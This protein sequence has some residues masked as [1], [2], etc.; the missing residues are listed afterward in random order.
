MRATDIVAPLHKVPDEYA[1]GWNWAEAAAHAWLAAAEKAGLSATIRSMEHKDF[2]GRA[3]TV[4]VD[5]VG[6]ALE[7]HSGKVR[8]RPLSQ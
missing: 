1:T 8:A 7:V 5:G 2:E 6:Y 3:A 4:D